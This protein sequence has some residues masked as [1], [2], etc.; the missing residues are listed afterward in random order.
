MYTKMLKGWTLSKDLQQEIERRAGTCRGEK[1]FVDTRGVH[2]FTATG[3]VKAADWIKISK[4]WIANIHNET[5]H[6]CAHIYAIYILRVHSYIT[7]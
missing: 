7:C 5:M 6:E 1:E 2:I 3:A 4:G